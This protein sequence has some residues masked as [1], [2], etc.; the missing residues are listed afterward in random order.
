MLQLFIDWRHRISGKQYPL[1]T[2]P[3]APNSNVVATRTSTTTSP[4]PV[5][6]TPTDIVRSSSWESWASSES[7]LGDW[8]SNKEK[9]SFKEDYVSFPQLEAEEDTQTEKA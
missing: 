5:P 7:S 1:S 8:H 6:A 2:P 4:E 9:W 3:H